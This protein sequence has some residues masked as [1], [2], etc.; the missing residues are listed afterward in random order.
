MHNPHP[1]HVLPT[2]K[3]KYLGPVLADERK[4]ALQRAHTRSSYMNAINTST[5]DTFKCEDYH[6][7]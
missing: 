6:E 4:I 1:S 5:S 2:S 3:G 7:Q